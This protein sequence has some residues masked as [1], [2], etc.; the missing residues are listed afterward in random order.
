MKQV[1]H[2]D[3]TAIQDILQT[4][5]KTE[6]DRFPAHIF[7]PERIEIAKELFLKEQYKLYRDLTPANFE[8]M[9]RDILQ[10]LPGKGYEL[11][12]IAD[13]WNYL[14]G[15]LL[16]LKLK[17]VI[18][19]LTS[20]NIQWKLEQVDPK[21]LLLVAPIGT[22]GAFGQP[23][24][25]YDFIRQHILENA[26]EKDINLRNSD[27]K[28]QDTVVGRDHFPVL[29][30]RESDGTLRL[31]DGNRRTLRALLYEQPTITAWVGTTT[32]SPE[33]QDYWVNTGLLKRLLDQY[34]QTNSNQAK[35]AIRNQLTI[36]LQSSRIAR[37]NFAE[38]CVPYYPFAAELASEVSL[39]S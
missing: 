34:E 24:Y 8:R 12:P 16:T 23:P 27:K 6:R 5:P 7:E 3:R 11:A 22:L 15:T 10:W 36:I 1:F 14:D 13:F 37:I 2:F 30:R 25:T 20:A 31:M 29:V 32:G 19:M 4:V 18:P 38:R 35:E 21:K 26:E 9:E 17:N 39:L 33:L 28:S